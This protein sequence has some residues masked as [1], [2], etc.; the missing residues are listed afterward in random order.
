MTTPG[1]SASG[2]WPRSTWTWPLPVSG[3]G[4]AT[5]R[6]PGCPYASSPGRTASTRSWSR[7]G[8]GTGG[9]AARPS[10]EGAAEAGAVSEADA[11]LQRLLGGESVAWLVRRVRD[12]LE[13]GRPLTGTVTL[14]AATQEQRRAVERLTGRV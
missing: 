1:R 8:N 14:P 12:R 4:G 9:N 6:S 5:R 2:S 11:R 7:R 3:S 10:S 13:A